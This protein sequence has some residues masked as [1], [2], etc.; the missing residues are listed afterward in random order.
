[1]DLAFPTAKPRVMLPKRTFWEKATAVH[2]FCKRGFKGEH[3]SRHWHD[4]VRL[5]AGYPGPLHAIG[6]ADKL[7]LTG[8][9]RRQ[10]QK[11]LEMMKAESMPIGERLIA[12]ESALDREFTE[13]V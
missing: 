12:Q 7:D 4:L 2:V 5:D 10:V 11:L 9:Q 6:L 1:V 13:H 8:T 3:I